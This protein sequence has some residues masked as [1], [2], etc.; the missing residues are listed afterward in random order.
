[1]SVGRAALASW[2]DWNDVQQQKISRGVQV[3]NSSV[4]HSNTFWEKPRLHWL[5]CN[6]DV[7][8]HSAIAAISFG[9]CIRDSDGHFMK[10][11]TMWQQSQMTVLEG[12]AM[13]LL[14]AIRFA[15][16]NGWEKVVFESDSATVVTAVSSHHRGNSEFHAIISCIAA[17]LVLNSNFEVKFIR[18]QANMVAHTLARAA[19]SWASHRIFEFYPTCIEQCLINDIS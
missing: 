1:M 19:C 3:P 9:C 5:K 18:R 4:Q 12:E 10:A 17:K 16:H 6:V 14:E 15:E 13:A 2:Q 11:Q 8:V 7:A